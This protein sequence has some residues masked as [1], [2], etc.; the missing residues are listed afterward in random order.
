VT[1]S[2]ELWCKA[3]E[4]RGE[5]LEFCRHLHERHVEIERLQFIAVQIQKAT[6]C[7]RCANCCRQTLVSVSQPEIEVIARHLGVAPE[8]AMRRFTVPDPDHSTGRTLI[9]RK[10]ACIFLD[11]NLCMIYEARPQPCR[12]FP[13]LALHSHTLG[14]RLSSLYR[15][16]WI[17]PIVFSTFERCKAVLGWHLPV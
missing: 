1:L 14:A 6:D 2:D 9:N 10:D 3:E 5:N 7:T 13:H 4:K 11:G 15:R 8:I 12:D 17:C 16:T